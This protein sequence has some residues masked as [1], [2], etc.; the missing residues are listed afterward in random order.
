[1]EV[2]DK[3]KYRPLISEKQNLWTN[4]PKYNFSFVQNTSSMTNIRNMVQM[5]S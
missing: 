2:G 5:K 4:I 3:G 1:M